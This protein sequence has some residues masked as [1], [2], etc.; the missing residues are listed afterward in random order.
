MDTIEARIYTG[1]DGNFNLYTDEGD[2]YNYE[3]GQYKS[4]PF[5]WNEQKQTLIIDKQ[6][7]SFKGALK[8]HIFKIVWVNESQGFGIGRSAV[9]R[10]IV[11]KG[12][13]ISVTNK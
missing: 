3:K 1:A 8:T 2:N 12:E 4:V 11:Y 6:Q 5:Q 7:G 9:T 13:K 10:S